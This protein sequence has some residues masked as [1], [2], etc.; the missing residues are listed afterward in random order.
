MNHQCHA[1]GC[2]IEVDPA[3]LMCRRHWFMVPPPLR[4]EVWRTYRPGQEDDK[5]PSDEYLLAARAA[6][7][8]VP[9]GAA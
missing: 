7:E 1:R 2:E 6:I 8:A 9:E 5:L 4:R 3:L